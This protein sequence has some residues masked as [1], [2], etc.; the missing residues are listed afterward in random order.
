MNPLEI[1]TQTRLAVPHA[2][3]MRREA[4]YKKQ[5][6]LNPH[7]R[8]Q[9]AKRSVLGPPKDLIR[10]RGSGRLT[11]RSS[12]FLKAQA[13]ASSGDTQA[14]TRGEKPGPKKMH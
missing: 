14:P 11:K 12:P 3:I 5:A 6:E 2:E 4:E 1:L 8:A 13:G 10:G 9:R 7:K